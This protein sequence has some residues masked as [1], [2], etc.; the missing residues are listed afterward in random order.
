VRNSSYEVVNKGALHNIHTLHRKDVTF[1]KLS[2][3]AQDV[4]HLTTLMNSANLPPPILM[5]SNIM[6]FLTV[7]FNIRLVMMK[8]HNVP[9]N[10]YNIKFNFFTLKIRQSD[11]ISGSFVNI[12]AENPPFLCKKSTWCN[13]LIEIT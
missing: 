9:K 13:I 2:R 5:F 3:A 11:K 8:I 1:K 10:D 12:H 6:L 7:Q 4:H